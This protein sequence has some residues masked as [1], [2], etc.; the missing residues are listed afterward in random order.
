M[1]AGTNIVFVG[2]SD[3]VGSFSKNRD[4]SEGRAAQVKDALVAFA[5][6]RLKGVTMTHTGYGEVAPTACNTVEQGRRM[7]RRVEVWIEKSAHS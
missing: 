5:G 2:F 4:L 6:D 1:P 7:N 3:N